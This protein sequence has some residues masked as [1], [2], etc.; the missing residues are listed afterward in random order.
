MPRFFIAINLPEKIKVEFESIQTDLKQKN[1]NQHIVWVKPQIAHINLHFLGN[2]NKKD[3]NDLKLNLGAL[4]SKYGAISMA[5]TGVGV[6]PSVKKPHILFLGVKSSNLIKLYQ[7]LGQLLKQNKLPIKKRPF[8]AHV[9]LGRIK[10]TQT[11][12]EF[13]GE[14]MPDIEFKTDS[15][16]LMQ[17]KIRPNG[18]EYKIIQSYKL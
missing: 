17:S 13:I 3:I 14:E 15:F 9:T 5:L 2:L 10:D 4:E 16:E 11:H 1:K 12:I 8:I 18:P 7:D 6:F